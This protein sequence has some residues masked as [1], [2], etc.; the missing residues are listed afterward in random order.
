MVL[1]Q[2]A[3]K[4]IN[5]GYDKQ[6]FKLGPNVN[7]C[8]AELYG[9][10]KCAQWLIKN[11]VEIKDE[12]CVIY[13]DSQACIKS[14]GSKTVKSKLT[15]RTIHSQNADSLANSASKDPALPTAICHLFGQLLPFRT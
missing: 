11:A 12:N 13:V 10:K 2:Q 14:L 5:G 1:L 3:Y 6:A 7:I 4:Y 9:V 8:Q 15:T